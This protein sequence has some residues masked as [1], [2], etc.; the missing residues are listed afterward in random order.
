MFLKPI[1]NLWRQFKI[2]GKQNNLE[3][4][5]VN[6]TNKYIELKMKRLQIILITLAISS[7]AMANE[8]HVSPKGSDANEGSAKNPLQTITAA[9]VL[10][11]PGDTITVHAGIYRE[12]IDPPRGGTSPT[13][14]IIYQAAEGEVVTIK[15]SEVILGWGQSS[16]GLWSITLE[17][18]FFGTYNPYKDVIK[19]DWFLRQGRDHHTGEIYLNG[20]ALYEEVSIDKTLKRSMSWYCTSNDK[21]TTLWANFDKQDPTKALVEGNAR[22][23]CFYPSKTGVNYITVRGFVMNQAAT[24]WAAPTSEQLAI[25]GTNWSKG[26]I[27]EDNTI[28]DSKCVGISLGKHGDEFDNN[29]EDSATGYVE[30]IYRAIEQGWS[31]DNVGSHI[32]RNNIVHDCGMAGI[33]GSMGCSFSEI[34]GNHIYNINVGKPFY[35]Y[36]MGAIKFHGAINTLIARNRINNCS[37]ALWLDWMSQGTRVTQ[38]LCYGSFSRD[39]LHVEVNHGPF[40]IDNNLFL[41]TSS[42]EGIKDGSQGGA[43]VHNIFAGIITNTINGRKTPYFKPHTTEIAGIKSNHG[44]INRYYNN[45]FLRSTGLSSYNRE[46]ARLLKAEGNVYLG[47]ATPYKDGVNSIVEETLYANL[48]IIEDKD[49]VYVE[50][51]LPKMEARQARKIITTELLGRAIIPNQE[52]L[53]Y[54]EE[55]L[56]IN[57]DY[58]GISYDENVPIAGPFSLVTQGINRIKVWPRSFSTDEN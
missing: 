38:N 52:F 53:N 35:G 8:Y 11:Q 6:Q 9:A 48:R 56:I 13:N 54:N 25:L 47:R 30:T 31:K 39:D 12:R 41:S 19:G 20:K 45:L 2:C 32:V 34:T 57:T 44:G 18:E 29:S 7:M 23:T 1:T 55:K 3:L 33:C 43:Y 22:Q 17:N 14:R 26:W 4:N 36:E 51:I 21:T 5:K 37:R 50:M 10:A 27:I 40:V 16:N 28:S 42:N 58:F 49:E 15:G 46:G 24:Q